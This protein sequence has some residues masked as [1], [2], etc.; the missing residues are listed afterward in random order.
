MVDNGIKYFARIRKIVLSVNAAD[1]AAIENAIKT[2]QEYIHYLR[3]L[4]SA[5]PM[6]PALMDVYARAE[7]IELCIAAVLGMLNNPTYTKLLS[8]NMSPTYM[9]IINLERSIINVAR[10]KYSN[11]ITR[12][13][14]VIYE[15]VT[16]LIS[17]DKTL[18]FLMEAESKVNK[19][20]IRLSGWAIYRTHGAARR[21]VE[22]A[23]EKQ[24]DVVLGSAR[25]DLSKFM[26]VQESV[27]RYGLR[28]ASTSTSLADVLRRLNPEFVPVDPPVLSGTVEEADLTPPDHSTMLQDF[29][30]LGP[31]VVLL[32]KVTSNPMEFNW[33][34]LINAEYVDK[35]SLQTVPASGLTK[36]IIN[37][38][39]TVI[40]LPRGPPSH[41][42]IFTGRSSDE[43][44]VIESINGLDW[45]A[46]MLDGSEKI[47]GAK[48]TGL[49][50]GLSTRP[51]RYNSIME[52]TI[53]ARCNDPHSTLML[54]EYAEAGVDIST[55][56][57]RAKIIEGLTSDFKERAE[58]M[59]SPEAFKEGLIR[60]DSINKVLST[61]L[62]RT[63]GMRGTGSSEY[64]ITHLAKYE[65]VFRAVLKE[66][67]RQSYRAD[68][69]D[70]IFM[71]QTPENLRKTLVDTYKSIITIVVDE[72]DRAN[73]WSDG[74]MT[75][76]EFVLEREHIISR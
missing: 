60:R 58:T 37:R 62:M 57:V 75:L 59:T 64:V 32:N 72:L 27:S 74:E 25:V 28:P 33:D 53:L 76:K 36:K 48:I 14:D 19:F 56:L 6:L 20:I 42:R 40:T 68:M 50:D 26:G 8:Y 1:A 61:V 67:E 9:S 39:A 2:L 71:E 5:A 69:P 16:G 35:H 38:F 30:A 54:N 51:H 47:D 49:I 4:D 22:Q 55:E 29:A 21:R 70:R 45:R 17:I 7:N 15:I 18:V 12:D 66:F 63:T 10:E 24:K 31:G 13:D 11:I 41:T 52:E 23:V 43:W 46:L 3:G 34:G 44:Y 65:T 73:V